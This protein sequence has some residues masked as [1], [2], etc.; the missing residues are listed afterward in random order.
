MKT[1]HIKLMFLA[2]FL[3]LG[4]VSQDFYKVEATAYNDAPTTNYQDAA[5]YNESYYTSLTGK[6]SDSLLNDL[7]TLCIKNHRY[8]T[9]Y[10]EI[11]GGNAYS[12]A[13]PSDPENYLLDFYTG[14]SVKNDWDG[15]T[16]WNREH[17]WA[18]SL[19]GNLF[20][21]GKGA[22]SDIHHIRPLISSI[23]S[24]R[25]NALY[26]DLQG[27]SGAEKYYYNGKDT[28]CYRIG[29]NYFEPRDESKGD[30]ARILMYLYTH[31]S[32]KV[33]S[34]SSFTYAGNLDITNI[35]YTSYNTEQKSFELL[36]K[37][38]KLDPVDDFENN[39]N[40]YCSKVTGVRNPFVDHPEFA[41]MIWDKTYTGSGALL[42]KGNQEEQITF[43]LRENTKELNVSDTYQI[44]AYSSISNPTYSYTSSNPSV[45]SVDENGLVTALSG[46]IS[47]IE[48]VCENKKAILYVEVKE[49]II[50]NSGGYEKVTSSLQDY[51]G[52]Y[53][54]VYEEST[55]NGYLFNG[56]D[57]AN[58][59]VQTSINQNVIES[60]TDTDAQ[61]VTIA[62]QGSGYSIKHAKGYISGKSGSNALT[63]SSSASACSINYE[64]EG[65]KIVSN[66][67]V[68]RFN[69]DANQLRFRFYKSSTYT[70]QKPIQ[71]YKYNE[72]LD[73]SNNEEELIFDAKNYASLSYSTTYIN[74]QLADINNVELKLSVKF[75]KEKLLDGTIDPNLLSYKA[76]IFNDQEKNYVDVL[77]TENN[78][79]YE[80]SYVTD[81]KEGVKI[82]F[83]VIYNEKEYF[84]EEMSTS[85][86][87]IIE[88][89]L[90]NPF[91][92]DQE[93]ID[94]IISE[95]KF[96]E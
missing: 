18:Q 19:S 62:K 36:L 32:K 72:K 47:N 82:A 54:I 68:L 44:L 93:N 27:V 43:K 31:Y 79:V 90:S 74:E 45:A 41:T 30:V 13:D 20:G 14:W 24:A 21:T 52:K 65:I 29:Q 81:S 4:N 77:L 80:L 33:S 46:G 76:V 59:Y 42:D 85:I 58:G 34:N 53:L 38:N 1:K 91:L 95:L 88:I 23:N 50:A 49:D 51:S 57:S 64:K 70:G 39:R 26:A 89:Y 87:D 69:S 71:L 55:S 61:V 2:A 12:D 78:G 83:C 66:T 7:A 73:I 5:T 9:S 40:N 25:N 10:G 22:G 92:L 56:V 96:I 15:G 3:C 11:R 16:T 60:N 48:V 8:F 28:G 86:K 17:V 94:R 63:V 37:W 35:V 75:T 6:T 67:S 84:S